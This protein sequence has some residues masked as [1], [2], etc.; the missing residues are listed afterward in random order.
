[1]G[2]Q[3]GKKAMNTETLSDFDRAR[4]RAAKREAAGLATATPERLVHAG[5]DGYEH[6]PTN[7]QRV[8]DATLDRMW[9]Q[10]LITAREFEAGE[11]FRLDAHAAQIDPAPAGVD[12]NR[13]GTASGSIAPAMFNSQAVANARLRWRSLKLAIPERS[14]VWTVLWLGLVKEHRIEEIG[15][16]FGRRGHEGARAAGT[17]AL[18]VALS[19]LADHYVRERGPSTGW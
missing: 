11:R 13:I 19:A 10:G 1:M 18:R 2:K 16:L 6:T 17:A 12:L 3:R 7:V 15:E 9:K 14:A 5:P 4:D 8:V